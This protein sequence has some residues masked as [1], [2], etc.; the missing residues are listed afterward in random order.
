[1]VGSSAKEGLAMITLE[2]VMDI[3]TL[4]RQGLTNREI[5][6]RLGVHRNTV[7]RHIERGAPPEYRKQ[8]RKES[9]LTPYHQLIE[10]WLAQDNYRGTWIFTK[11]KQLGYRG[12]YDTLKP[13]V[14]KIKDRERRQ[15]YLRFET[16]PGLQAQ[17]DWADFQ[18]LEPRGAGLTLYLFLLVLGFSRAMYAELLSRCTLQSF[19]DAHIR[20]FRYL[21]GV[22]L[23]ILYDNMKNVVNRRRQGV[24]EF[25]LEFTHFSRHYMFK[26]VA[27]PPYSPWYKGKVER[28]VDYIRESFWRGYHYRGIEQANRDLLRW[29]S[30]TANCRVHATHRQPV[31]DRWS[32]DIACMSHAPSRDYDTSLKVYRK[33]YKDCLV[34]YDASRYQLPPDVVGK[35]VLLKVKDGSIRFF[36]DD[37]LLATYEVSSRKGS[38]STSPFFNEQILA[39]RRE[40]RRSRPYGADKGKATRGLVDASLYP[41]VMQRPLSVYEAFAQ[42]GDQWNN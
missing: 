10:D 36:D 39:L 2:D 23:E 4:H 18:V 30:E 17:M 33:V 24:A 32:Q 9:I 14:R 35:K 12:S 26:P 21:G 38:C 8:K 27:C 41:Q 37:R 3:L 6:R 28:P 15:A 22:P 29:L 7:T 25:N 42:A 11:I 20:A 31:N 5:S 40:K 19:M 16:V 1:M 34:S 13:Y